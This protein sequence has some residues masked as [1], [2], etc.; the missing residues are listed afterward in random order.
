MLTLAIAS[1]SLLH[2]SIAAALGLG[3]IT[4][5]SAMGQPLNADIELIETAGLNPEDIIV[6]LAPPEAFS[7]AGIERVF[8]YNDLRFTPIIRGNR[9]VVHVESRKAVTEPYLNFLV[10][11]VRPSGDQ[12]HEYTVLLD[13]PD[14]PAGLSA[15]RSRTN[16]LAGTTSK[17]PES[18]M[19]VAPPAAVDGKHYTV[20][21]GD[22]LAS[23][24][25]R[26]QA[27]G[28]KTSAAGLASG[29]QALNPQA[30]PNGENSRLKI[31]Q[32][33]LLPD[34]AMT[35]N[36]AAPAKSAPTSP[37]SA[38]ASTPAAAPVSGVTTAQ[39]SA[40]Q[41]AEQL[42]A[43]ALENQQ[44]SKSLDDL[45]GKV[46]TAEEDVAGKN[47][48]ISELQTQ[49]AELKSSASNRPAVA[50]P[51]ATPPATPAAAPAVTP[52]VTP[53]P[54]PVAVVA[55]D[56]S[57]VPWP[58][59]LGA[60]LILL[61]L[62]GLA[63]SIRRN[64]IKNQLALVPEREEPIIKPAQSTV[65]P[66]FEVPDVAPR[67]TAAPAASP[68]SS[69]QRLAGASTD[70]L[71]G[72]SIYIA[73]GRF[74]EAL[75]ILREALQKQPQ[76][77]DLRLR[78]L[79][80]LGEQG[81]LAAFDEEEKVLLNQGIEPQRLQEIRSRYPKLK[82][83]AQPPVVA[84]E[85]APSSSPSPVA[86]AVL[87]T[88]AMAAMAAATAAAAPP[89]VTASQ[90][91]ENA[92]AAL[93]PKQEDEFQL[94]LDDLSMDSDWDLV[95]PFESTPAPRKAPAVVPEAA[96]DPAF[97]SNLTELPEV[98]EM[99]DEQFL[100]DFAEPEPLVVN[101]QA[102][103]LDMDMDFDLDADLGMDL[104]PEPIVETVVQTNSDSLDDAFLDGFMDDESEFDL[105]DL[106]EEPLSKINQA[107]VLIDEGSLDDARQL[108]QEVIDDSNDGAQQTARD[109]LAG[110]S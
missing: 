101:E 15:T 79:E 76:R 88:A 87:A 49:L 110:I 78:I 64:R 18:R 48:Q 81:D 83:A 35:P 8:F 58:L 50:T 45:K 106:E 80:L 104:E 3:E 62:L 100:S 61:L 94:N 67:P 4:L 91:D 85:P 36:Q 20:V 69:G 29:I 70:A 63:Y 10:R 108:L 14:S 38:P 93:N 34:A 25:R 86:P 66:V 5:H 12:L 84:P 96:A 21:A 54:A 17:I 32:S 30:F 56:A 82:L 55:N 41:V 75:A 77:T 107:Q 1:A 98:F 43:T 59:L 74:T 102:L 71:D 65:T 105:L 47:R 60:I 52:A 68:S 44:L 23:I 51:P 28:S 22:T 27:P 90:P 11:L 9:G 109:L 2:S 39:S 97:A 31:G 6:G 40:P 37:A 7:K 73:Y 16:T 103:D 13:P 19:P 99:P 26:L 72:A 89:A 46:Q 53:A 42:T 33:L 95:D 57:D 24:A 92:A